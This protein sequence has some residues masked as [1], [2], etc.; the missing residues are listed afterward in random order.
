MTTF[1][2]F[3]VIKPISEMGSLNRYP[4]WHLINEEDG[5]SIKELRI[6]RRALQVYRYILH[7]IDTFTLK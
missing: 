5:E 7:L 3:I 2:F 6:Y 4:E 1:S